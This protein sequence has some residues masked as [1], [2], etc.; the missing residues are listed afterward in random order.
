MDLSNYATKADLKNAT[1]VDASSLPKKTDLANLKSNVDKVDT[2]KLRTVPNDLSNLKSEVDKVDI[3]N[4]KT[5]PFDL[6]KQSNVVK[7]DTLKKEV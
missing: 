1:G 2:D 5:T 4:L 3:G 7:S 6:S